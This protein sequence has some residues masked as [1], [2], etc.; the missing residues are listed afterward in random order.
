MQNENSLG[1]VFS[2]VKAA[3]LALAVSFLSTVVLAA[4][5]RI[6]TMPHKA[7]YP[8]TQTLKVIFVLLASLLFIRGEKGWLKGGAVGLIFTALSYLTFSAVGGDFSL[9]WLVLVEVG[10]A[11]FAGAL[12]GVIGVNLRR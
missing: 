3:V 1:G 12:G 4:I 7:I 2:I 10:L 5:L 11:L 6:T 8:I 9:S